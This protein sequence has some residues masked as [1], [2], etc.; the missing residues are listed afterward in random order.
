MRLVGA[1]GEE[2]EEGTEELGT[3]A[4]DVYGYLARGVMAV[5]TT[6]EHCRH[7]RWR[8]GKRQQICKSDSSKR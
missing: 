1:V 5:W 2:R 7:A 6:G 8:A 3:G 4:Q